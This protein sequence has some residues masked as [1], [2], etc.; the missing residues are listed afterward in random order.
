MTC[1]IFDMTQMGETPHSAGARRV[2]RTVP[3]TALALMLT[4]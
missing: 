2:A 4:S 3:R 1:E